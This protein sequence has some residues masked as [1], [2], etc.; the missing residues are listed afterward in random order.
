MT[1]PPHTLAWDQ[2]EDSESSVASDRTPQ[3]PSWSSSEQRTA[4]RST[5]SET[6][7]GT[8]SPLVWRERLLMGAETSPESLESGT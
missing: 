6:R 1:V 4:E 8:S 3:T 2:Q 5:G 7:S